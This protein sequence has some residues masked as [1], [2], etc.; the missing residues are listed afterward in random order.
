MLTHYAYSF[1]LRITLTHYMLSHFAY[2]LR[3]HITLT[4]YAHSLRIVHVVL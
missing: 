2:T 3:L 1:H 4:H